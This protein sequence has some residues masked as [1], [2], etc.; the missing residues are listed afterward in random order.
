MKKSRIFAITPEQMAAINEQ[1]EARIAEYAEKNGLSM[2]EARKKLASMAS[3]MSPRLKKI[4]ASERID[5]NKSTPKFQLISKRGNR[6][7]GMRKC[8]KCGKQ[9]KATWRYT[10]STRGTVYLCMVCKERVKRK[11]GRRRK[12][13]ALDLAYSGGSFESNSRRH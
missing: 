7:E 4:K 5:R 1:Y 11:K 8:N 12:I 13:D 2:S 10:E 3:M 6:V 9:F